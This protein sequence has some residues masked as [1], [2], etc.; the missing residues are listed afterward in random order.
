VK[1][2]AKFVIRGPAVRGFWNLI[3][4]VIERIESEENSNN[5]DS[6]SDFLS[7]RG[8]NEIFALLVCYVT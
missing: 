8:V 3:F 6:M 7:R 2:D 1:K 5:I 4:C